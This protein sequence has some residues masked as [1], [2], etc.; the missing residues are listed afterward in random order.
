MMQVSLVEQTVVEEG[1]VKSVLTTAILLQII[2]HFKI[3][4][5]MIVLDLY[6][7]TTVGI[8][9][10]LQEKLLTAVVFIEFPATDV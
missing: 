9:Y 2:S 10:H 5:I 8:T 3:R 7:D 6:D 1:V 4:I